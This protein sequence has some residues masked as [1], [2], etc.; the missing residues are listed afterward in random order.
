MCRGSVPC[1]PSLGMQ[2]GCRCVELGVC[3]RRG[4]RHF[5]PGSYWARLQ[6]W[7]LRGRWEV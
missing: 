6:V 5:V 3:M 2:R 4:P 7:G 1:N